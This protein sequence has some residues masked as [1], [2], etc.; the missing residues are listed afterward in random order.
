MNVIKEIDELLFKALTLVS[1]DKYQDVQEVVESVLN[2]NNYINKLNSHHWQ[3]IADIYLSMGKLDLALNAYYKTDNLAGIAFTLIL[4]GSLDEASKVLSNASESPAKCWCDF[5]IDLFSNS[6]IKHWPAFFVIRHFI[7]FTVYELLLTNN[8]KYVDL[9]TSKLNKLME[10]NL[11][12]E[13]LIGSAY[14]HYGDH[15]Q[16]IKILM[17][18]IKRNPYDGEVYFVLGQIYL[19]KNLPYAAIPMFNNALLLLPNYYPA[20]MLLEKANLEINK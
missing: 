11:D 3:Y 4:Q 18:V 20:K 13:K 15:E 17:N 16:A 2:N 19:A 6:K 7:E 8:F 12:S 14:F 9:F 10:I 5:L 1:E